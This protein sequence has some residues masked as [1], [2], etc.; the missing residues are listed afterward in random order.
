LDRLDIKLLECGLQLLVIHSCALVDL[1]DLS[2]RCA[3]STV[4]SLS[5]C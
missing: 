5:V 3:L 2:S 4:R 1:L